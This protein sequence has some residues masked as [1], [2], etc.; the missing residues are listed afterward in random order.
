MLYIDEEAHVLHNSIISI[1]NK[2]YD[3]ID[4]NMRR[5]LIFD[6]RIMGV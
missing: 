6:E 5:S 3:N 1:N 4:I 2:Q